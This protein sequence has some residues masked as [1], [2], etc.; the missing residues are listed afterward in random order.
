M[1][2]LAELITYVHEDEA[3]DF[4]G[5]LEE[6]CKNHILYLIMQKQGHNHEISVSPHKESEVNNLKTRKSKRIFIRKRL[7]IVMLTAAILFCMSA[8][9]ANHGQWDIRLMEFGHLTDT[10]YLEEGNLY[11]MV[12]V[13]TKQQI[14]KSPLC[15][16]TPHL[17]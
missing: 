16:F 14:P 2:N 3:L 9:A 6:D 4:Q 17:S 15:I 10:A 11:Q 5:N 7:I 13:E 8:F 12:P 1:T